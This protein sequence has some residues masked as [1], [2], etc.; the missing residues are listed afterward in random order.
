MS[1]WRLHFSFRALITIKITDDETLQNFNI[2]PY[3]SILASNNLIGRGT[4][5]QR[6]KL[7]FIN[8]L[9]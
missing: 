9:F 8:F 5:P 3:L 4:Q 1:F 6:E 7:F 2:L